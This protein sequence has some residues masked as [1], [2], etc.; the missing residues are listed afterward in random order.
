MDSFDNLLK[1]A[2][3]LKSYQM[4]FDK[5]AFENLPE[6]YKTGLYYSDALSNVRKQ[7]YFLQK[8]AYEVNRAKGIENI[9]DENYDD[10][11]YYFC[12]SLCIFKYIKSKNPNWKNEAIKDE[13]L[14]YIDNTDNHEIK[15]MKINSLLN[16][17]LC[18]LH[19]SH[20]NEVRFACDEVIKLDPINIKA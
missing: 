5:K 8:V 13:D 6:F 2:C 18:N 7:T 11:L 15:N 4:S 12:K 3:N 20:F 14:Y 16:I 10:A 19:L 9:K 1:T 17:A